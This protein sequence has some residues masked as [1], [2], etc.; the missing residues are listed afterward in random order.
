MSAQLQGVPVSV[1]VDTGASRS[2]L[3]LDLY[4][5]HALV[6]GTLEP[7]RGHIESADRSPITV[8][9]VTTPLRL[10]WDNNQMSISFLI[11]ERLSGTSGILGM[12]VLCPLKVQINSERLTALPLASV[13]TE[14]I[15][16]EYPVRLKNPIKLPSRSEVHAAIPHT[17]HVGEP[18]LFT[19]SPKLPAGIKALQSVS[20]GR[21]ANILL[22]NERG[23]DLILQ[24][25]WI[26]GAL[27]HATISSMQTSDEGYA[28][29]TTP[30]LP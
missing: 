8:A 1:L 2:C 3:A 11:V 13:L 9:G 24:P 15:T 20:Q 27:E 4:T 28:S 29:S 23:V 5:Q 21:T 14:D 22:R 26:V 18:H 19:P 16:Y 17:L 6:W 30:V 25:G 10:Q 7:Y 12:D